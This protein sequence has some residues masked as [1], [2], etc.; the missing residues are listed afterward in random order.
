[1][2]TKWHDPWSIKTY[3]N[4]R[5]Y[6]SSI[7]Y[8]V[9]TP[10]KTSGATANGKSQSTLLSRKSVLESIDWKGIRWNQF[11]VCS[12]P[13]FR[14]KFRH[15]SWSKNWITPGGKKHERMST[16]MKLSGLNL[17]LLE[18]PKKVGQSL[19]FFNRFQ[20]W[21]LHR[22]DSMPL[23]D[24]FWFSFMSPLTPRIDD[25]SLMPCRA[26]NLE[27]SDLYLTISHAGTRR[28]AQN[29]Q[30]SDGLRTT[31]NHGWSSDLPNWKL[32]RSPFCVES[33]TWPFCK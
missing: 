22:V 30:G 32:K 21:Q 13:N 18:V 4:Q 12:L 23:G 28:T 14:S 26:L 33:K 20:G 31:P 24:K 2:L 16:S 15:E 6:E 7:Q 8:P 29:R 1:M 5:N 25:N 10:N 19:P 27:E 17:P 9:E 3:Q 11:R